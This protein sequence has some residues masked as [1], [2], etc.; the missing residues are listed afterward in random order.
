MKFR[1]GLIVGGVAGYIYGAKAGR[2]KY[3]LLFESYTRL[4]AEPTIQQVMEEI[5]GTPID[6]ARLVIAEQ[7]RSASQRLRDR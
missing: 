1:T 3:D 2:E 4:K 6:K 7:L 5:E